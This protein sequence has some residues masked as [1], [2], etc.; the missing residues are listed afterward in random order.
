MSLQTEWRVI[1]PLPR[2]NPRLA[3]V[4]E[5][6]VVVD[7]R[8]ST[9]TWRKQLGLYTICMYS[10]QHV[11][12]VHFAIG[13]TYYA[14]RCYVCIHIVIGSKGEK[15]INFPRLIS[16]YTR[17]FRTPN[18]EEAVDYLSL[19]CLNGDL[20]LPGPNQLQLC[21]EAL[22][23]LV[24]ETRELPKFIGDVRADGTREKGA[25]EGRMKLI[26]LEDRREFPKGLDRS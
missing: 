13:L 4:K 8:A 11:D 21:H 24:L 17:D 3:G 25:I 26:R 12:G 15:Q 1:P 6:T 5:K 23:E 9:G 2:R 16:Y 14:L 7:R 22:R 18:A 19:I 10:N 20:P